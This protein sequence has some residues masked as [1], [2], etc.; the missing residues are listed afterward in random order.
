MS[1]QNLDGVAASTG[2]LGRILFSVNAA[3]NVANFRSGLIRRLLADGFD[4][5]VATPRDAWVPNVEDLG[6][7]YVELPMQPQGRSPLADLILLG[8]YV[9]LM[10]AERPDAFLGFTAKA[11]IYG[12]LAAA[13]CGV[14]AINNIA[15]LGMVFNEAGTTNRILRG[16]YRLA[17][18]RSAH[19][20]FQNSE[21]LALF[22]RDGLV[23]PGAGEL[24][25]GSGVDLDRF[26]PRPAPHERRRFVFLLVARLLWEKGI[27]ELVAAGRMVRD[28]YPEIEI[29]LL[30]FVEPG[31]P[32]FVQLRDLEQWDRE[33]VAT[34]LGS[35][36]DVRPHLEQAD[37]VVLPSYYPEGTPRSLLEAAAM[38]KP[39]ITCDMPGCRDVVVDGENGYLVPPRNAEA[40]AARML[41]LLARDPISLAAMG[42]RSREIAETRFDEQLVL[43]R[44]A[45]VLREIRPPRDPA[46]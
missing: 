8:R 6:C 31:K 21:D 13:M 24:L 18:R 33:G 36:T 42:R 17:L 45:A 3:W 41:D 11:N 9:R 28:R 20:F 4:V 37:C 30:G 39:L 38:G 29:Q 43:N 40:L 1:Q 14:P 27:R 44:Y 35:A 16:L 15:G 22:R 2:S 46:P 26:R 34:Y 12:S 10:H 5:T 32:A 7:R 25:P 23:G 19:I